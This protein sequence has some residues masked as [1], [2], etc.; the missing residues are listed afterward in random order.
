MWISAEKML[1]LSWK[2]LGAQIVLQKC[3]K[4]YCSIVF[5]VYFVESQVLCVV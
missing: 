5:P 3:S 1:M 4:K 2:A